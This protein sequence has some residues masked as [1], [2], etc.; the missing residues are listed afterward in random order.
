MV[1][2]IV[3]IAL[4]VLFYAFF[5]ELLKAL[6]AFPV[7]LSRSANA[8]WH[9]RRVCLPVSILCLLIFG[10]WFLVLP[11]TPVFLA[12]LFVQFIVFASAWYFHE[13]TFRE[14]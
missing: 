5:G 4:A 10:L 1:A 6:I 14:A 11:F 13:R 8:W 7:V 3:F 2:F 9:Y 12:N